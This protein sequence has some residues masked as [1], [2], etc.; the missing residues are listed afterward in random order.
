MMG[1][2]IKSPFVSHEGRWYLIEDWDK[3]LP[4]DSR[5]TIRPLNPAE[6]RLLQEYRAN[7]DF[8][9]WAIIT[10]KQHL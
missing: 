2:R 3:T 10:G 5:L 9:A 8:E 4:K 6:T 1:K 7:F